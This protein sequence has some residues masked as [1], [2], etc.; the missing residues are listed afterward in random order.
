MRFAL[1]VAL[2]WL[3]P[4]LVAA[5]SASLSPSFAA[6]EIYDGNVFATSSHPKASLVHRFGPRAEVDLRA[7]PFELDARYLLDADYVQA[8]PDAGLQLARQTGTLQ[9]RY[10]PMKRLTLQ[11]EATY[12]D[13]RTLVAFGA[14]PIALDGRPT[15]PPVR[16]GLDARTALDR[17]RIRARRLSV[18]PYAEYR[19][20]RRTRVEAG[21]VFS[22]DTVLGLQTDAH[23]GRAEA[24]YRFT[25]ADTGSTTLVV[26]KF[27]FDMGTLA[28]SQVVL[29]GWSH[30]F[31]RRTDAGVRVGPRFR[32]V[33]LDGVEAEATVRHGFR[34]LLLELTYTRGETVT[35]GL[36]GAREIDEAA[37]RAGLKLGVGLFSLTSGVARTHGSGIRADMEYTQLSATAPVHPWIALALSFA[38]SWQQLAPTSSSSTAA[39][40]PGVGTGQV[41]HDVIAL[42]AVVAPPEPLQP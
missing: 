23:V 10:R 26:R 38:L 14:T 24:D 20:D 6:S 11:T 5:Q 37:L 13:T 12:L 21:Y 19:V 1:P 39:P 3:V 25:R 42:T 29:V 8:V 7:A 4:A 2:A 30:R 15:P 17:G 16:T 35:L 41:F 28:P 9:L 27:L 40:L 32:D 31:A 34:R 22:Q 18:N 33:A 36:P